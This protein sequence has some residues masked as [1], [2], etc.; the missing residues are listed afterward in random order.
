MYQIYVLVELRFVLPSEQELDL[1][2]DVRPKS[3]IFT[4]TSRE[5]EMVMYVPVA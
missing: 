4:F 5:P 1:L 2:K 3:Y